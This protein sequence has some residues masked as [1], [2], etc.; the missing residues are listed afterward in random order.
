MDVQLKAVQQIGAVPARGNG[1]ETH[2][3][4]ITLAL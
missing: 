4:Q 2:L 3:I 1:A